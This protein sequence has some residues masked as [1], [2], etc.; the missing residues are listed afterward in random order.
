MNRI[1]G[2]NCNVLAG[3][4]D[5]LSNCNPASIPVP[6]P[7]TADHCS[8]S[9]VNQP[10]GTLPPSRPRRKRRQGR[11]KAHW[12]TRSVNQRARNTKRLKRCQVE[13]LIAAD[14][15][16]A[17][18][19]RRLCTFVSI[20]WAYT[21]GGETNI[22]KR[23]GALLRGAAQWCIRRGFEWTAIWAHENPPRQDTAFNTHILCSIPDC[24]K[25]EF[26]AYLNRHL[27]AFPKAVDLRRRSS[28]GWS[29]SERLGY[30]CKGTDKAT[31]WKYRLI[32]RNGWDYA[33]GEV[34]FKR[35]GTSK[36]IGIKAREN[37]K[38]KG[39]PGGTQANP[40]S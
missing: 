36:N 6:L 2:S 29:N 8:N 31:A 16:A 1:S 20:R 15:F 25:R 39:Y 30:I 18:T 9:Y 7:T 17:L 23:W 24:F 21:E 14:G 26:E 4:E 37:H 12:A 22:S 35:C 19:Q 38:C 3:S 33:Q 27:G 11:P 40:S 32:G 10:N 28:P 34:T 5:D 13:N